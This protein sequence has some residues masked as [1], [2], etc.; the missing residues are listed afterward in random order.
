VHRA[1]ESGIEPPVTTSWLEIEVGG[2]R[3]RADLRDG[4]TRLGGPGCD[5]VVPGAPEGELHFWSDPPKMIR[6]AGRAD[7]EVDGRRAE[8]CLLED[9]RRIRWSGV[10]LT[11]RRQA[12][13]LE[14][15]PLEEPAPA[16]TLERA[17]DPDGRAWRRVQAGLAIDLGLVPRPLVQ[18][19]QQAVL[20]QEFDADSCAREALAQA[21]KFALD[22]PRVVERS[23]RLL[24][25]F[26]MASLQRGIAGAGRKARSRALSGSAYLMANAVGIL[27]YS[28]MVL[29]V[30]LLV[31]L[32]WEVSF[33]GLFDTVLGRS[34]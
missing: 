18:R 24:R 3:S 13:V 34:E 6:V 22:D 29:L 1:G 16:R 10:S 25:D 27:I 5:V 23:G 31:R 4:L 21:E 8:E 19:W 20:A 9:G 26:L 14:E 17:P 15:I 28:G 32:K 11:F 12:P 2:V 7:L 30:M 33:D